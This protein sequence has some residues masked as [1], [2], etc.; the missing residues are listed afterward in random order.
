MTGARTLDRNFKKRKGYY[1]LDDY[2]NSI[3]TVA[4]GHRYVLYDGRVDSHSTGHRHRCTF[5]ANHQR[6]SIR[7]RSA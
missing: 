5:G 7:L 1:A 2:C 6:K 4:F 3:G